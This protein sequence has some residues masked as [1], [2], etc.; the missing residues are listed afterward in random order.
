[1]LEAGLQ[2]KS[3]KLTED[4]RVIIVDFP[5]HGGLHH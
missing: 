5:V 3:K 4:C 2:P 1:M